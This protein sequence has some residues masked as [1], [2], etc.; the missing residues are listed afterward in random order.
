M[1]STLL[2]WFSFVLLLITM[3]VDTHQSIYLAPVSYGYLS[4]RLLAYGLWFSLFAVAA[5]QRLI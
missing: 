4:K 1:I 2:C 5:Y 3:A